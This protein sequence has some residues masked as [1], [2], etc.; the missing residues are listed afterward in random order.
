MWHVHCHVHCHVHA[1]ACVCVCVCLC[2]CVCVCATLQLQLPYILPN[3]TSILMM[4]TDI[5]ARQNVSMHFDPHHRGMS[6]N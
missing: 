1:R 2:V 6:T 4:D 3:E 5:L